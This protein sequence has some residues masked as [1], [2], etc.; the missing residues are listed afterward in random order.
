MWDSFAATILM[1][2]V[3]SIPLRFFDPPEHSLTDFMG[4]VAQV[5]WS[6]DLVAS[7]FVGYYNN[8]NLI[9]DPVKILKHYA[10]GWLIFDILIVCQGDLIPKLLTT[11]SYTLEYT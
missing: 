11:P 8:G 5:F 4:T 1:Y 10:F 3:I 7:F 2:D 6:I 9:M